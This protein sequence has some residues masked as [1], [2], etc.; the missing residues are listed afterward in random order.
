MRTA[1]FGG[2]WTWRRILSFRK[3]GFSKSERIYLRQPAGRPGRTLRRSVS[4]VTLTSTLIAMAIGSI[5]LVTAGMSLDT[6]MRASTTIS[7]NAGNVTSA[8]VIL[9]RAM[10]RLN[11]SVP[12]G[13]CVQD[14]AVSAAQPNINGEAATPV[15]S[16]TTPYQNCAQVTT[17]GT[18]FWGAGTN[19]VCYFAYPQI[20]SGAPVSPPDLFC[21]YIA[22]STNTLYLA[23][24]KPEAGT[25]YT[26]C[27]PTSCFGSYASGSFL[28]EPGSVPSSDPASCASG[29]PSDWFDLGTELNTTSAFSYT[30][31]GSAWTPGQPIP[32][33]LGV[34]V[35]IHAENDAQKNWLGPKIYDLK[36]SSTPTGGD[37]VNAQTWYS[38]SG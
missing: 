7:D 3:G 17:V 20:D 31:G 35:A 8:G 12:L 34:T 33:D 6:F 4:G 21:L 19:G 14:Q 28:P 37:G 10:G 9:Q 22:S 30:A 18:P 25:T 27:N 13:A 36:F 29:C 1:R 16:F 23:Q 24:W 32:A 2:G 15:Y 38:L 26:T 11:A 5:V